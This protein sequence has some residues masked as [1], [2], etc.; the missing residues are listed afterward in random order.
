MPLGVACEPALDAFEGGLRVYN[1]CVQLIRFVVELQLASL[2]NDVFIQ[3]KRMN[4]KFG[5]IITTNDLTLVENWFS[6]KWMNDSN[7]DRVS[8]FW[9]M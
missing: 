3:L 7:R 6:T 2:M 4:I 1:V 8:D 5:A 9:R